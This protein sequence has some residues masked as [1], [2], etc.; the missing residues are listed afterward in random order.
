MPVI[1]ELEK[2]D[3]ECKA[4]LSYKAKPCPKTTKKHPTTTKRLVGQINEGKP[5]RTTG[6]GWRPASQSLLGIVVLGSGLSLYGAG[7]LKLRRCY[8]ACPGGGGENAHV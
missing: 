5:Q 8:C 3:S 4:I 2:K 7:V 1:P 6:K